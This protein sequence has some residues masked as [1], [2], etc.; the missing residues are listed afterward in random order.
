MCLQVDFFAEGSVSGD[1]AVVVQRRL[2][3]GLDG[4]RH[5]DGR[6]LVLDRRRQR[7]RRRR[8]RRCD[9]VVQVVLLV[10]L[11]GGLGRR[12]VDG[13]QEV[14]LGVV[15]RR[16]RVARLVRT[17]QGRALVVPGKKRSVS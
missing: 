3:Q 12:L 8:H 17:V 4:R 5:V 15:G 9:G 6:Q 11:S 10:E 1:R 16:R 2:R 13:G 7:R 14:V